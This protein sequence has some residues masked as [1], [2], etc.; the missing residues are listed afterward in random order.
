MN[1]WPM[2]G[3]FELKDPQAQRF[4]EAKE[5]IIAEAVSD[6]CRYFK[7][8]GLTVG[9]D[10]F[11]PFVSRFVGQNYA[12]ITRDADFI[13]PMLYRQTEAP[14]G[15]GYEYALFR[16]HAPN[17]RGQAEISMDLTFLNAQLTAMRPLPCEKYPGIEI[18]YY[19]GIADTSAE[20]IEE[21]LAAVKNQGFEG[22]V[23]CW[24]VMEAPEA[25]I[26][27]VQRV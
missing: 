4:F 26:E 7:A 8:Q 22:A 11:A 12:L 27:A 1:V 14:A 25:H 15:P 19:K 2:S 5:T 20:Y 18:N 16:K 23:L 17:A 6:L 13:K 9:L 21:S 10:L 3:A 24:N